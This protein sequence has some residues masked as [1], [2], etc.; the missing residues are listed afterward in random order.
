MSARR[1]RFLLLDVLRKIKHDGAGTAGLGD[2]KRLLTMR[3]ISLMSV[4]KYECFTM[5]S[6]TPIMSVS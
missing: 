5:G 4:I 1:L 6:V 2:I 3:G